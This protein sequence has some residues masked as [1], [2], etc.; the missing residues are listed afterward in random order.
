[1]AIEKLRYHFR[2]LNT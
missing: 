2:Y 1:M